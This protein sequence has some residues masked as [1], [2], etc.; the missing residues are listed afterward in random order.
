MLY[1]VAT[2]IGNLEDITVRALNTLKTCDYILCED[3]RHSRILLDHYDIH[4]PL[5]SFHQFNESARE[6]SVL[7]DLRN[8][9]QIALISDAGT[10]CISDP[11]IKLVQACLKEN[12]PV[13]ALPGPCAALVALVCSGFDISRFQFFG[14]L[15][16]KRGELRTI[17][18]ELLLY[19]GVTV[20]YE[21][22]NRLIPLLE[23]LAELAPARPLCVGRELTKKFEEFRR[24]TALELLAVWQNIPLRGEIVLLID[25]THETASQPWKDL[26]PLEHVAW[27]EKNFGLTRHEAIKL[28]A[29]QRGV[30][31]RE[32]YRQ[33][34]IDKAIDNDLS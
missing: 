27:L 12:I 9:K 16:K 7:N 8:G 2:P 17:L 23:L 34:E 4:L 20:C 1:L 29:D 33:T 25:A 30:P 28:A 11:G 6:A 3:T 18:Q 26:D 24:G 31:K 13:T 5:T 22:P 14:F 15:P 32:V 21:S 10:P 19:P